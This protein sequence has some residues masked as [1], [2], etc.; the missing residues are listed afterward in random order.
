[1]QTFEEFYCERELMQLN[2]GWVQD[3]AQALQNTGTYIS[4][5]FSWIGSS[6]FA[7]AGGA[8][9]A[10]ILGH[11]IIAI[12][13]K[14]AFEA[15]Q[16]AEKQ[17]AANQYVISKKLSDA[18]NEAVKKG[19]ALTEDQQRELFLKFSEEVAKKYKIPQPALFIKAMRKIG[20]FLKGKL[21]T[22][23]GAVLGFL[24]F[25]MLIPFPTILP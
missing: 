24:V 21:G 11:G 3:L 9:T 23:F 16:E 19:Q 7:A 10:N 6:G 2:E 15:D 14:L 5:I 4:D 17:K 12:S 8:A 25:K 13:N 20:E 22:L 18:E 1:M